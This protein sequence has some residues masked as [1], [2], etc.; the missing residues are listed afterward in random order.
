MTVIILFF[1]F[2]KKIPSST[3]SMLLSHKQ[4][5]LNGHDMYL[6]HLSKLYI[7]GS[8]QNWNG[9]NQ[10]SPFTVIHAVVCD[11][12]KQRNYLLFRTCNQIV[13]YCK[14]NFCKGNF[15][16]QCWW[17]FNYISALLFCFISSRVKI[18]ILE[19]IWKFPISC[20]NDTWFPMC[21]SDMNSNKSN[22]PQTSMSE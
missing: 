15:A 18:L 5:E 21:A 11:E 1:P 13:I 4:Q 16:V 22:A 9:K 7:T 20:W 10:L 19:S 12:T 8:L 17:L 3:V 14:G 6:S 2:K